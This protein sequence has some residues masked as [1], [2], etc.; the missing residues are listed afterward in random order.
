[1]NILF[2]TARFPYPP[3]RGDQVIPYHRLKLLSKRHNI[4]LITFYQHE[5][6]LKYLKKLNPFCAEIVTIKFSKLVSILNILRG[7]F[8]RLPFQVL[9]FRSGKFKKQMQEVLLKRNFDIIHTYTLRMAEYT[10]NINIPKV[11]DL[12]D[13]MQLNIERRLSADNLFLKIILR[14]E[15]MRLRKYENEIANIYD[16]SVVV[17][18]R[19]RIY[20]SSKKV[21]TIPLGVDADFFVRHNNLPYNRTIVFSGNM[22][23]FPNENAIIWF[24]NNCLIKIKEK[25]PDVRLIIAGN[26]PS[27]KVNNLHNGIS[28][29][30]TGYVDSIVDILNKAQIAI[31]PMQVGSGMQFKIL[32]AMA[33]ALPV[34]ITKIGLGGIFYLIDRKNIVIADNATDFANECIELLCN[35]QLAVKIGKAA[36]EIIVKKYSWELNT[37]EIEKCYNNILM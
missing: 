21:L 14:E 5:K 23:Y 28:V 20:I 37:G 22:G 17:S 31:A 1:M 8:L 24:V 27:V 25:V 11:I 3:L 13:S 36:R 33:C 7:V 9:Y 4:T 16:N 35:Y 19:D 12:I 10:R 18:E 30:V 2:V 26:N 29:I 32:E 15:L 6:E 34:V